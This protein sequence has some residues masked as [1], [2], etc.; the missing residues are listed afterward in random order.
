M[1]DFLRNWIINIVI[2]T[3]FV[4]ITDVILPEGSIKKYVKVIIGT[5][6]LITII[7]PFTDIK[8]ISD[9]FYKSYKETSIVLNGEKEL[10][11]TEVLNSYQKLKAIEIYESRLKEQI[12]SAVSYKTSLDKTNIDVI[13]DINT[14]YESNKYGMINNV[15]VIMNMEDKNSQIEKI[16]NV[17]I[18]N[19]ENVIYK[20]ET[21][22]TFN[23]KKSTEDV[24]TLLGDILNIGKDNIQVKLSVENN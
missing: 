6:I 13:L 8:N 20:E 5:F 3:I 16:K 17:E 15:L 10:I 11:D 21:E 4:I 14:N 18:G 24:K 12:I 1:I 9:D 23:E 22:Y 7:K 19:R 2:V